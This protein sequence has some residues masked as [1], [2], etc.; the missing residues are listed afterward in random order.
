MRH[1]LQLSLAFLMLN[2][3][4]SLAQVRIPRFSD[5]P[6]QIVRT[7]KSAKVQVHSTPD[8][9]CFRTM[10]RNTAREGQRFAG[11]YAWSYWGCGTECARIGIVDLITGRAYVS[12]FYVTGVGIK[13]RID[14]RLMLLNDPDVV[15][16]DYG[17][18]VPKTYEPIYFLWTGRHLL[19]VLG[20]GRIGREWQRQF[21]P[22]S[23]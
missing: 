15:G 14:S 9:V 13:T 18:P 3:T 16:K 6:A 4:I 11:R 19:Q 7:R 20:N 12:P 21:D 23:R 10:L 17:D 1:L 22:C 8:T 5:Y 2:G